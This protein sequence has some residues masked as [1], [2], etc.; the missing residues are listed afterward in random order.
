MVVEILLFLCIF[1]E[2]VND[3]VYNTSRLFER[4]VL[5]ENYVNQCWK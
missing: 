1:M 2:K 5:D 3:F 4:G